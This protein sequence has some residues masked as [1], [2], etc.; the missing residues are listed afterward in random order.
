MK[1]FKDLFLAYRKWRNEPNDAERA[2][3]DKEEK[4]IKKMASEKSASDYSDERKR[5]N[6]ANNKCPKCS[7]QSVVNKIAHVQGSGEVRGSFNYYGGSVYGSSS[8]VTNEVNHCNGCGN[9]W[10]KRKASYESTSEVLADWIEKINYKIEGKYDFGDEVYVMLKDYKA[11]T[12]LRIAY[13]LYHE[14]ERLSSSD[15][16]WI[17]LNNLRNNFKSVYEK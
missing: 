3:L 16:D 11:E 15:V 6:E 10:K 2:I 12:I 7:S 17:S 9:Q 13:K 4:E 1:I 14:E 8:T 5:T